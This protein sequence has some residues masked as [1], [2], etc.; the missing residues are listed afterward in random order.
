MHP[1]RRLISLVEGRRIEGSLG[2]RYIADPTSAEFAGWFKGR[3]GAAF[4]IDDNGS[5]GF[6]AGKEIGIDHV[7][8]AQTLGLGEERVRGYVRSDRQGF[9]EVWNDDESIKSEDDLSPES[10]K[11][12]DN[13]IEIALEN[14]ILKRIAPHITVL[15]YNGFGEIVAERQVR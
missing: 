11:N 3:S 5:V 9:I 10:Q 6:G 14:P 12:A 8:I 15:L 1:F 4:V 7:T 13:Q 2:D